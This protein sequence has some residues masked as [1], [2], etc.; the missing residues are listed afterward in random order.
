MFMELRDLKN[1]ICYSI[2]V[3]QSCI[4]CLILLL[5]VLFYVIICVF[6]RDLTSSKDINYRIL[7]RTPIRRTIA[8]SEEI[9]LITNDEAML[10]TAIVLA[11]N[12]WINLGGKPAT[13]SSALY[14]HKLEAIRIIN[15]RLGDST[16]AVLVGTIGAVAGMTLAEV[17]TSSKLRHQAFKLTFV[18]V[19]CGYTE[20]AT[21]HLNGLENLL[22]LRA[23]LHTQNMS[24]LI[25]RMVLL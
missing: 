4:T 12:H 7:T 1:Q 13:V 19:N 8:A 6:D 18:Q 15:D 24:G 5:E 10:H 14:H 9:E 23:V 16:K 3:S 2:I 21:H 11:A 20:I 17:S 25:H 22:R